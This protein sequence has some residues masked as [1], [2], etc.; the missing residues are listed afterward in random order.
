MG[1][2]AEPRTGIVKGA[3]RNPAPTYL[4]EDV[5]EAQRRATL[6]ESINFGR[7][8]TDNEFIVRA[9]IDRIGKV[10]GTRYANRL[11]RQYFNGLAPL[12]SDP[13]ELPEVKTLDIQFLG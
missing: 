7:R 12:K 5:R 1:R 10:F 4:P 3:K 9:V 13:S 6:Q 2:T 8:M 11:Y